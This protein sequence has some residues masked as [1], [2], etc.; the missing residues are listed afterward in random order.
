MMEVDQRQVHMYMYNVHVQCTCIRRGASSIILQKYPQATYIH[1]C[2]HNTLDI[3]I[4]NSSF[5]V[6]VCNMMGCVSGVCKF[7]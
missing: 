3:S 4:A 5:Q 7:F 6:L 1:C 2:S